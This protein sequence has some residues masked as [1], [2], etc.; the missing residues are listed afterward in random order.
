MWLGTVASYEGVEPASTLKWKA[1]HA[2]EIRKFRPLRNGIF[3]IFRLRRAF[4][5]LG[6]FGASLQKPVASEKKSQ[7]A[8]L[9]WRVCAF[10]VDSYSVWIRCCML[11]VVLSISNL[12]L[13]SISSQVSSLNQPPEVSINHQCHHRLNLIGAITS[14]CVACGSLV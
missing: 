3:E 7:W 5:G 6:A 13:K 4:F 12:N 11:S 2:R 14:P 9:F 8:N 1:R 10:A